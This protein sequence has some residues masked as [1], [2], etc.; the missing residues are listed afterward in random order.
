MRI[1]FLF[2]V[3]VLSSAISQSQSTFCDSVFSEYQKMS[4]WHPCPGIDQELVPA[5][6]SQTLHSLFIYPTEAIDRKLEGDVLALVYVDTTGKVK[7]MKFIK[8]TNIILDSVVINMLSTNTFKQYVINGKMYPY[9]SSVPFHF[10]L[11]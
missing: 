1:L 2:I 5:D 7:C 11:K 3:I 6:S 10:R 4:E 8:S 9:Y